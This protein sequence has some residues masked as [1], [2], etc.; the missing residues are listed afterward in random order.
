LQ[1][2]LK[3][4]LK[5]RY[6]H[7]TVEINKNISM[8]YFS[9]CKKRRPLPAHLCQINTRRRVLSLHASRLFCNIT[10]RD[11]LLTD[12]MRFDGK[13]RAQ[14]YSGFAP[15]KFVLQILVTCFAGLH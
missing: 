13:M 7:G 14:I 9:K 4:L 5:T 3:Q 6:L 11:T 10:P 15:G 1:I 2:T 8:F 12:R